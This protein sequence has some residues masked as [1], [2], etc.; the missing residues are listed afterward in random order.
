MEPLYALASLSV[1]L[2]VLAPCLVRGLVGVR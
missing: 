2:L 1:A